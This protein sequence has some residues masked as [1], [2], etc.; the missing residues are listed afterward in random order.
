MQL[1][2]IYMKIKTDGNS[3]TSLQ[4]WSQLCNLIKRTI[5]FEA[6]RIENEVFC[7]CVCVCVYIVGGSWCST[8]L[9]VATFWIYIL[10]LLSYLF[11]D[12]M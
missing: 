1:S 12:L 11:I 10:A 6:M 8:G 7:A 5:R 3:N 4:P 2:R 9:F